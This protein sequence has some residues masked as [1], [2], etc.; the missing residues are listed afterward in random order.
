MA[1]HVVQS[2]LFGAKTNHEQQISCLSRHIASVGELRS[3][4]SQG[5]TDIKLT[6]LRVP[7]SSQAL[8]AINKAVLKSTLNESSQTLNLW[9]SE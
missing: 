4:K 5:I 3:E 1:V 2:A 7:V 8:L 9:C 6:C